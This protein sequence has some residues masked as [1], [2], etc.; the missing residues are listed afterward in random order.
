MGASRR[1]LVAFTGFGSISTSP[2]RRSWTS[3]KQPFANS[4]HA[5]ASTGCFGG[6]PT[7]IVRR[8]H[9]SSSLPTR[10][11]GR[12]F[13][14]QHGPGR[15]H[16]RSIELVDWQQELLRHHPRPLLRGLIHSDGC[17][18]INTGRGGWTCPRYVFNHKSEGI[19]QIF[20]AACD[21]LGL[22][23]TF[24]PSTVYVSRKLDVA[25]MDQFIGPKA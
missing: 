15:K 8:L 12:A 21:E 16:Q 9:M 13:S 1:A 20:C 25:R 7:S 17:R 24:A 6:A 14:P 23:Y 19:L 11:P 3:A 10:S 2:I 4:C 18:F 22:R 5:T